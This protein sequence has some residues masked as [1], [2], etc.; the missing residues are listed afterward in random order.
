MQLVR[1]C[2][3]GLVHSSTML[4]HQ[5]P[6][7]PTISIH[8]AGCRILLVL[9]AREALTDT[10]KKWKGTAQKN[11]QQPGYWFTAVAFQILLSSKLEKEVGRQYTVIEAWWLTRQMRMGQV[12]TTFDISV[13]CSARL[14]LLSVRCRHDAKT[15]HFYK[16]DSLFSRCMVELWFTDTTYLLLSRIHAWYRSCQNKRT[17]KEPKK[18][19]LTISSKCQTNHQTNGSIGSIKSMRSP[20]GGRNELINSTADSNQNKNL[21]CNIHKQRNGCAHH[22]IDC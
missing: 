14:L 19:H 12:T 2:S 13:S 6:P 3:A 5:T 1:Q 18:A 17:C 10:W 4:V 16:H 15:I 9:G 7:A 11:M 8:T 22:G 21:K 20:A